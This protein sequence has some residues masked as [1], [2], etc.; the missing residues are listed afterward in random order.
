[1]DQHTAWFIAC[2]RLGMRGKYQASNSDLAIVLNEFA[3]DRGYSECPNLNG[4]ILKAWGN[5]EKLS[6]KTMS[7]WQLRTCYEFYLT[8][9]LVPD[10][11]KGWQGLIHVHHQLTG[12]SSQALPDYLHQAG[13]NS[14][15]AHLNSE[16][17]EVG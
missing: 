8:R 10:N 15:L 13:L 11:D 3:K 7:S 2:L 6:A 14:R 5:S 1:M 17:R 9:R 12:E 4:A 16:G